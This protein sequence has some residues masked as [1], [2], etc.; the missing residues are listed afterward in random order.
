MNQKIQEGAYEKLTRAHL[1]H[2]S[3]QQ[4]VGGR[5]N[6]QQF[7]HSLTLGNS[8]IVNSINAVMS[9]GFRSKLDMFL[10]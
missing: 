6:A 3:A 2:T 5:K 4:L 8:S 9:I 7:S 1:R 10:I